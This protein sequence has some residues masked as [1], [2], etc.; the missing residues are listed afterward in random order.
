MF[1]YIPF[2]LVNNKGQLERRPLE[3]AKEISFKDLGIND[4]F[5]VGKFG[6]DWKVVFATSGTVISQGNS[7]R[8]EARKN[9]YH[10][11]DKVKG[12]WNIIKEKTKNDI[13]EKNPELYNILYNE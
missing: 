11:L 2:I 5:W 12:R 6:K 4:K 8:F 7:D 9:A 10:E 3:N 1:E 13:K